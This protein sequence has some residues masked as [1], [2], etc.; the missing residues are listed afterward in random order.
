[1][2]Q[3]PL[4]ARWASVILLTLY[5]SGHTIADV[6][7]LSEPPRRATGDAELDV[8]MTKQQRQPGASP[9]DIRRILKTKSQ[10]PSIG[11]TDCL[12]HK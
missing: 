10:A 3:T 9:T 11:S 8:R 6:M 5:Q 12:A 4:F 2:D 1:M 7:Q